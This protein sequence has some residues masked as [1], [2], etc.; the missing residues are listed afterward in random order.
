MECS[1]WTHDLL[2]FAKQPY[3][4]SYILPFSLY[5]TME[6]R[7]WM[8]DFLVFTKQPYRKRKSL[9]N[10]CILVLVAQEC[11][12]TT[13]AQFANR[14]AILIWPGHTTCGRRF[15]PTKRKMCAW[16]DALTHVHEYKCKQC[17]WKMGHKVLVW[18][19]EFDLL[20]VPNKYLHQA[21]LV[22]HE[23]HDICTLRHDEHSRSVIYIS[24]Q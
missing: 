11:F 17:K 21:F 22:L 10:H 24:K 23:L 16:C 15:T 12:M 4:F 20:H 19:W 8:R 2:D 18:L 7:G 13:L 1:G 9:C 6:S 3:K 5:A 14:R